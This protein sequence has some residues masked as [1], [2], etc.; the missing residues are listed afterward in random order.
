MNELKYIIDEY[1]NFMIFSPIVQHV[2]AARPLI[3]T[4]DS[5]IVGAGFCNIRNGYIECWGESISLNV[6]SRGKI[7]SDILNK[8]CM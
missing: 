8:K 3:N 4:T 5:L 2:H 7:D 1:D 6:K